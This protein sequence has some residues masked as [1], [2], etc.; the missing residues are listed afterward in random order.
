MRNISHIIILFSFFVHKPLCNEWI[1]TDKMRI[2]E[3][4]AIYYVSCLP[5]IFGSLCSLYFQVAFFHAVR[6]FTVWVLWLNALH[7]LFVTKLQYFY[8]KA[9]EV[10]ILG[11][12]SKQIV[13]FL[14]VT[15][16]WV[17]TSDLFIYLFVMM[18]HGSNSIQDSDCCSFVWWNNIGSEDGRKNEI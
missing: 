4:L 15:K 14:Q 17:C 5:A 8:S 12:L 2:T 10:H 3:S 11:P 13:I 9:S 6:G 7:R 18:S 16:E 1:T